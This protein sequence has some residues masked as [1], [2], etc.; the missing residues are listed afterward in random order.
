MAID[1]RER[2]IRR[3]IQQANGL[4]ELLLKLD[5]TYPGPIE[6]DDHPAV[7]LGALRTAA[8]LQYGAILTLTAQP[9]VAGEAEILLRSLIEALAHV[10]WI[11]EGVGG[12]IRDERDAGARAIC[13]DLGIAHRRAYDAQGF[14]VDEPGDR[15]T[16][17]AMA[18]EALDDARKRHAA[19]GCQC[20]GYRLQTQHVLRA[21]ALDNG[22]RQIHD[23]WIMGSGAAHNFMPT[24]LYR[25]NPDG[26]TQVGAPIKHGMRAYLLAITV[27]V[28]RQTGQRILLA[29][30]V[31]QTEVDRLRHWEANY[32]ETPPLRNA[33]RGEFD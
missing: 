27:T 29:H 18:N 28:F 8:L 17:I 33:L 7:T 10:A 12:R 31:A 11:H 3:L 20:R 22:S 25:G 32:F 6:H 14:L 15:R 2:G 23:A 16:L 19:T 9:D 1:A 4:P 26:T 24:R 21:L 13:F 5:P 30:G